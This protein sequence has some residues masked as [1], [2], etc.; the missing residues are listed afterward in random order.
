MRVGGGCLTLFVFLVSCERYVALP[1]GTV[2]WSA[3]HYCGNY[4]SYSLAR[5]TDVIIMDI[6]THFLSS[7][8]L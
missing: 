5:M 3:V 2:G 6:F 1:H 8:R 7:F 4:L